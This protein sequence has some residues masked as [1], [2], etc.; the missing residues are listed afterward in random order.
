M[1]FTT[2]K[3]QREKRGQ[4]FKLEVRSVESRPS[5]GLEE[6][7]KEVLM[8]LRGQG[9]L[10]WDRTTEEGTVRQEQETGEVQLV[11]EWEKVQ[12]YA[13]FSLHPLLSS[14]LTGQ[15]QGE[16]N[17]QCSLNNIVCRSQK[18]EDREWIF[19]ANRDKTGH[20]GIRYFGGKQWGLR[21]GGNK[22]MG[23][24]G[25]MKNLQDGRNI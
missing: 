12:T 19:Q 13:G 22:Y 5:R 6:Q 1:H 3:N 11:P 16:A 21:Q 7:G 2:I 25:K 23:G 17:C 10:W 20:T 15:T 8:R 4:E 9:C 14:C 24:G 18:G